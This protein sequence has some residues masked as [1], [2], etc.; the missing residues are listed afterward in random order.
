M[1]CCAGGV[2]LAD[3]VLAQAASVRLFEGRLVDPL[4]HA[5]VD[6][7][8]VVEDGEAQAA[9]GIVGRQRREASALEGHAYPGREGFAFCELCRRTI[10]VT[11]IGADLRLRRGEVR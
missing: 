5:P 10:V 7:H 2:E 1:H 8:L 9:L 3:H 11:K 6:V 4:V